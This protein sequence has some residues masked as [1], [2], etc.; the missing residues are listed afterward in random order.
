[1]KKNSLITYASGFVLSLALTLV[2]YALIEIHISS[3]HTVF[4]HEFLLTSILTLAIIQLVVQLFFFLH[5]GFKTGERWR[6]A[7]F[8]STLALVLLIV[9]GSIWIMSH[10]NY[11]MTPADVNQYM[12]DQQGGF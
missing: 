11:N 12:K 10:L 4:T 9:I 6:M 3:G 8:L 1:M 5:L 2:A 7:I